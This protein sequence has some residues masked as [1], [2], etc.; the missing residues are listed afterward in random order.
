[1]GIVALISSE[2]VK[3]KDL[4]RG[5]MLAIPTAKGPKVWVVDPRTAPV[6]PGDGKCHRG[7]GRG[8]TDW[9]KPRPSRFAQT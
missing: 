7:G 6:G 9:H 1:M 4:G 2:P 8:R 3:L 5:P